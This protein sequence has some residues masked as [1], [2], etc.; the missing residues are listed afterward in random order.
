MGADIYAVVEIRDVDVS[1]EHTWEGFASVRWARDSA[2]FRLLGLRGNQSEVPMQGF[3]ADASWL[4]LMEYG[5]AVYSDEDMNGE[6]YHD[7]PVVGQTEALEF[8]QSGQSVYLESDAP[9]I[10]NP[11]HGCPNWIALE[12]LQKCEAN[13][14]QMFESNLECQATIQVMRFYASQGRVAR[15]VYWFD[16]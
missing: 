6:M 11:A 9:M 3:P 14:K 16:L 8:I 7:S 5:V 2:L 13:H 15:L 1:G 4:S 12:E 10:S